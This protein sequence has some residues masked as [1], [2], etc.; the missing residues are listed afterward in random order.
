M[1]RINKRYEVVR[2]LGGGSRGA[3]FLVQDRLHDNALMALKTIHAEGISSD[4]YKDLRNE[5]SSVGRLEHPNLIRVFDFG[6]IHS[7]DP[8]L[9]KGD[10]F[11][12]LEYVEGRPL[13]EATEHS[14]WERLLEIAYQL[15]ITLDYIHR[16]NLIHFD[17]KPDNILLVQGLLGGDAFPIAKIIDFGFASTPVGPDASLIRG[18]LEYLAPELMSKARFDHRIDLYSLGVTLYQIAAHRLPFETSSSINTLKRRLEASPPRLSEIRSDVHPTYAAVVERL[19]E[20]DPLRRFAR[21][22]DAALILKDALGRKDIIDEYYSRI[23]PNLYV[24]RTRELQLLTERLI[25]LAQPWSGSGPN[26]DSHCI[27]LVGESGVGKTRLLK[28]LKLIGQT[29]E[30]QLLETRCYTPSSKAFEPIIPVLKEI[31][32]M[33]MLHASGDSVSIGLHNSAIGRLIPE[34]GFEPVAAPVDDSA[35]ARFQILEAIT[36]IIER[37]CEIQP[38]AIWI[39]DIEY[40]DESTKELVKYLLRSFKQPRFLLLLTAE[41]RHSIDALRPEVARGRLDLLPLG[42]LEPPEVEQLAKIILDVDELPGST[43]QRILQIL[44]GSPFVIRESLSPLAHKAPFEIAASLEKASA[45][46]TLAEIYAKRL[47]LLSS[48]ELSCIKL[49]SCFRL[50]AEL[51]LLLRLSPFS[52]PQTRQILAKLSTEGL[53]ES[54]RSFQEHQIAQEQFRLHVYTA[55]KVASTELHRRIAEEMER[56]YSNKLDRHAEEIAYHFHRAGNKEK[57]RHY[58]VRA[59]QQEQSVFSLRHATELFEQAA[60][61]TPEGSEKIE[62][63]ERLAASLQSISE[64][65]R[66]A[67]IYG[68]LLNSSYVSRTQ[69]LRILRALSSVQTMSGLME[70]SVFSL[71]EASILAANQEEQ[72]G[73]EMERAFVEVARGYYGEAK[74]RLELLLQSTP[75]VANPENAGD[76]YNKLGII[77]FYENRFRDAEE[78]FLKSLQVLEFSAASH[79]LISPLMNLG[80]VHGAQGEIAKAEEFWRRALTLAE[81]AGNL[82]AEGRI[83]NNLGIALYWKEDYSEASKNYRKAFEI[84]QRLGNKPS[85]GLCMTNIGEI[86]FSLGEYERALEVW[87][88]NLELFHSLDDNQGMAELNIDLAN[89]HLMLDDFQCAKRYLETAEGIIRTA[90]ITSQRGS[91]ALA[92]ALLAEGMGDVEASMRFAISSFD[93]FESSQDWRNMCLSVLTRGRLNRTERQHD[94]A[95]E[96]FQQ[97]LAMSRKHHFGILEAESLLALGGLAEDGRRTDLLRPIECYKGAFEILRRASLVE[98]T[99]KVCLTLAQAYWK[100]GLRP[101]AKQYHQYAQDVLDH[102]ASS[103]RSENLREAFLSSRGRDRVFAPLT[104]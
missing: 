62:L 1:A 93:L 88:S 81:K 68:E 87:N 33:V 90:G 66:A 34:F 53:I 103:F 76:I 77:G 64:F 43:L 15:A 94:K 73:V 72:D 96:C 21:A 38:L 40:A 9:R 5:F 3:V 27:A 6:T 8:P 67:A 100:R 11:F 7:A 4:S 63:K 55:L 48:D 91:F 84:F 32:H 104:T 58:Y 102:I 45:S 25:S 16:H 39:D 13:L 69:R 75:W 26:A 30:I 47:S 92:Q 2:K 59:A 44:G 101:K 14:S 52:P 28:E 24:G 56:F 83:H 71:E 80:N 18:T 82:N 86:H 95:I 97:S 37:R 99:W 54:H 61:L 70:Q 50:T 31:A 57:A 29:N 42:Q 41:S 12:T 78:F 51:E 85:L 36:E 17:I 79:R 22:S 98:T 35:S 23:H 60:Q 19:C 74:K 65:A 10:H 89:V 49:L 20:P 46:Q